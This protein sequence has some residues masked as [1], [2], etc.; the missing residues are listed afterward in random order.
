MI[1]SDSSSD[2]EDVPNLD[3]PDLGSASISSSTQNVATSNFK[4][5]YNSSISSNSKGQK[6]PSLDNVSIGSSG[7]PKLP[8]MVMGG[9]A[10]N[11]KNNEIGNS[12][13]S[14]Q[15]L[16]E[17]N[18]NGE[19]PEDTEHKRRLQLYVFV[20][21][22]IAYPFNAKQPTDMAR[23][24]SKVTKQNLMSIKDRFMSFLE[25][26]TNIIADEAFR[27]AVQSYYD[28]FLCCD[29]VHKMVNSGGYSS[30]DFREIFK[31]NIEKRVR[32]LPDI[33]GLSKET[34]LSSWMAKFDAI[35]RGDEDQ[36]K[37]PARLAATA[38]SE[39]ILSKEQLYEMFQ[40][41]LGVRKYEHQIL[42]NA[43]QLDTADEQA[44]CIR[45]ELHSRQKILT[46]LSKQNMPKFIHKNMEE[47]Y[48]EEQ[49]AMIKQLMSIHLEAF[50]VTKS[51]SEGKSGWPK[52]KRPP[53]TVISVMDVNDGD[54][55][56]LS[57][58]VANLTFNLQVTVMEASGLGSLPHNRIVFVVMELE[59]DEKLQTDQAE[60]GR[61]LWE[62]QGEWTTNQPLPLLKLRLMAEHASKLHLSDEKELAT[63]SITPHCGISESYEWFAMVPYKGWSGDEIKLKLSIKMDKPTNVKKSGFLY[64]KGQS[65]WKVW[66]RRYFML[67][68]VSQYKFVLC[69]YRVKKSSPKEIMVVEGYTADFADKSEE[70]EGG[71]FL[72]NMVKAGDEVILAAEEDVDRLNWIYKL[73]TATG[74]SFKPALP[75]KMGGSA[76]G[77]DQTLQKVKGDM[78]RALKHGLGGIVQADPFDF[79]QAEMFATLQRLTLLHRLNDSYTCLG[80]FSPGQVF[81]LDEYTARYGV[82]GCHRHLCYLTDLLERAENGIMID[83][84]LLHYSYAFCASHV[85]GNRPDGV[86]TVTIDEKQRF[87]EIKDRLKAYLANQITHFRYCFP[88]GRPEGAL[89]STLTLFERVLSKDTMMPSADPEDSDDVKEAIRT[90][91]RNA[92]LV[93]YTRLSNY[94]KVPD[95]YQDDTSAKDKLEITLQ[96][97]EL[98]IELIQQNEE[99]HA[100]A[101]AWYNELMMEHTEIFWSLFAVDMDDAMEIQPRDAWDSFALFQMLNNYL[102][103]ESPLRGGKFHQ[104]LTMTFSPRVVRYIDL[105]E[106]SIARSVDKGF[107]KETYQPVGLGCSTSEEIFW[108]LRSI[109]A[110]IQDLHWPDDVFAEHMMNRLKLMAADMSE[111]CVSRVIKDMKQSLVGRSDFDYIIPTEVCVMANVICQAEEQ[112]GILCTNET[113]TVEEYQYHSNIN[114]FIQSSQTETI[115]AIVEK[116]TL[117]LQDMLKKLARYDHG[118]ITSKIFT[119]LKPKEEVAGD[120]FHYIVCNIRE[121]RNS[122]ASE[123]YVFNLEKALW[124]KLCELLCAWLITRQEVPL[125][126]YQLRVLSSILEP[127]RKLFEQGG[128]TITDLENDNYRA[129]YKKLQIEATMLHMNENVFE[130]EVDEVKGYK[131]R[132]QNSSEY[133]EDEY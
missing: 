119:L 39:L 99:H 17:S 126:E 33:E 84:T 112:A 20:S 7:S 21:R 42:F 15:N 67:I 106:S 115:S 54:D 132:I 24:Q 2:E 97:A 92:A 32:S 116:L 118:T 48:V 130:R 62:T 78:D 23:R 81:V 38:A 49:K 76:L 58:A 29:R 121:F 88:F 44:A 98:C 95:V 65:I 96:L 128:L 104:H 56:V 73:Y 4:P 66:K 63:L 79:N 13:S 28:S 59:G 72:F 87:E 40:T 46:T 83:P 108:K 3:T 25:G 133:E 19:Y 10:R 125:H 75:S 127:C 60:A 94:A 91:L 105:M 9:R 93:N 37:T 35:Y 100:E 5:E 69:S 43:C 86:N 41:V 74:Q 55:A 50:P 30:N 102:Q 34:V 122:M 68:Q 113:S 120:F 77:T 111:A 110:F 1:E 114:Q 8:R 16:Q 53:N 14:L 82:R 45:R 51:G 90:C 85:V 36:K 117:V 101:L 11:P 109:Q 64:A 129:A 18:Q 57:K 131:S 89:K 27:N 70:Y 103:M 12:F 22:C 47:I 6:N 107:Q 80:W 61:P 26:K 123:T 71:S 31:A 124:E 52:I